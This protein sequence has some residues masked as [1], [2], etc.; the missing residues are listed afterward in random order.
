VAVA[1]AK[2]AP[3][4]LMS[5]QFPELPGSA[6]RTSAQWSSE[7]AVENAAMGL[8]PLGVPAALVVHASH[9]CACSQTSVETTHISNLTLQSFSIRK[10]IRESSQH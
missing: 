9:H 5:D 4:L 10:D 2:P 3:S 8:P 6:S 1:A 7:V